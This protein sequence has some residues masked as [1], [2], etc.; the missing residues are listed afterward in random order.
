MYRDGAMQ[1]GEAFQSAIEGLVS[2]AI[3]DGLS[4]DAIVAILAAQAAVQK[5]R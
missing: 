5:Y 4:R 2:Q 3:W 1:T